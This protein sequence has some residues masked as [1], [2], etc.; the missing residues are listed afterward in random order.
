LPDPGPLGFGVD[1]GGTGIKAAPVRLDTGEPA[2]E[3]VRVLT[4][5]GA[6]PEAVCAVVAELVAGAGWRGPVGVA[7]PAVVQHGIART[8][9]NVSKRWIG[10]DVAELMSAAVGAPVTVLNDADAAGLAEVR[11]G[12]GRGVPGVVLTLTLGTGI[13]SGLFS[14]G[15]LV[16]NTE[17]GHL[18]IDGHDAETRAS[19]AA[20]EREGLGWAEWA[21]RLEH[22]L[23]R[24][25]ALLWPDLVILGGG[26]S[27]K[28][29]RWL[30][31]LDVRPALT[32][33]ALRNAAGVVGAAIACAER[34]STGSGVDSTP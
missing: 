28:A 15:T 11:H 30:P 29:D 18:E 4:P 34:M 32:V 33:A 19:E 24:L 10:L 31:L 3:R 25:D 9:A 7:F 21:G 22:Y 16:P 20:R 27:K 2:G 6:E 17:L 26:A 14:D 12:A 13:G 8:A 23:R 5:R 1:I